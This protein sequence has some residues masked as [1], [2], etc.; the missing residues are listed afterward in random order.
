M[1]KSK[2]GMVTA[3]AMAAASG[4]SAII[5]SIRRI[6]IKKQVQRS[7]AEAKA[8]KKRKVKRGISNASRKANQKKAH[9]NRF[10]R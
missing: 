7:Q 9:T 10:S 1:R 2:V 4:A 6:R 5:P 3:M 8:D